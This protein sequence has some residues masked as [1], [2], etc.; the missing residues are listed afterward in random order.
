VAEG[1]ADSAVTDMG[2]LL[3]FGF[4]DPDGGHNEVIW[5]KPHVPVE[6]GFRRA[7]WTTAQID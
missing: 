4:V 6:R 7:E 3:N 1:A 2:S 5:V